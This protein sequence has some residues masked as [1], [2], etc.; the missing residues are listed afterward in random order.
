MTVGGNRQTYRVRNSHNRFEVFTPSYDSN[1]GTFEPIRLYQENSQ[2]SF[3][4]GG[5]QFN[6]VVGN[7]DL[8]KP[9]TDQVSVAIGAEFRS[10]TFTI[11]PGELASY[12]GGGAIPSW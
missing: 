10:E 8:T 4:Q 9:L 5:T 3:D 1:T 7:I 12:D 6:H 11:I 2:I